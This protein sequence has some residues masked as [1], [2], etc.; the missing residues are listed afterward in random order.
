MRGAQHELPSLREP[1][2]AGLRADVLFAGCGRA[3]ALLLFRQSYYHFE[4]LLK[5]RACA[6]WPPVGGQLGPVRP[7]APTPAPP[8]TGP[9]A[10]A[11]PW[12]PQPGAMP[13]AV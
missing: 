9:S 3:R 1:T 6:Y 4:G 5:R 2:M 13:Q 11:L 7:A 10:L 8:W 12:I